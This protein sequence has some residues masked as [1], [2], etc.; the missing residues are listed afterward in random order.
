VSGNTGDG[1]PLSIVQ[2]LE[3]S[4]FN[5]GSVH[6]MYQAARGLAARGHRVTVVCRPGGEVETRCAADGI[7]FV[8]LPLRGEADLRSGFKLA[9]VLRDRAVDVVH[10]HKGIAHSIALYASL[11]RAIPCF[12]VN[13]GVSFPI[14]EWMRPKYRLARVHRV[15]TVCED[16]RKVVIASGKLPPEKVVVVYAGVDLHRFDPATVQGDDVRRELGVPAGAFLVN[17]I[18]AREWKGWRYLVEAMVEVVKANPKAHLLLVACR[19]REQIDEVHREAA[20]L[21]VGD[22]VTAV[23]YRQDVPEISAALDLSVDLSYEGL[24][25]TGTLREAMAMGKPVVCSNAGGN[26]ELVV[27]GVTGRLVEPRSAAGAAAAIIELMRDP[28]KARAF[29]AAGRKRVEEGFSAD[30]R[31]RRLES[32]YRS[33]LAGNAAPGRE[34]PHS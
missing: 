30:V 27:D 10:V 16:I 14:D 2:M 11:R 34:G 20:R 24:G 9:R 21:G 1:R 32:L 17:Q 28:A 8:G 3:K 29:G 5:T 31:M 7:E 33:V 18:G 19:D 23:G 12:I 6:Q 22:H 13:R 15:V 4:H 26:P 25:I